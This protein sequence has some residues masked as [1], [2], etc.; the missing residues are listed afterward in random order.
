MSETEAPASRLEQCQIAS[1]VRLAP[2][3]FKKGNAGKPKGTIDK[4][5]RL[6][7]EAAAAL[8][9]KC[10]D[11][12]ERLLNSSSW[13]AR[14]EAVKTTLAYALGMPRQM[15]HLEGGFGDLSRELTAAL[16][17]ARVRRAALDASLPA[18]CLLDAAEAP[19]A[20]P[21]GEGQRGATEAVIEAE[22]VKTEGEGT[23]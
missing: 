1:G 3:R 9:G 15:V 19:L 10:W 5:R 16:Q 8:E 14:H 23:S 21:G 18:T 7:Q 2:H 6:G 17:E 20:L 13:R 4:R 22:L 12:L 11:V